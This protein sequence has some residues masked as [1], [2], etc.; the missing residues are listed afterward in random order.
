MTHTMK[1]LPEYCQALLDGT[2]TYELRQEDQTRHFA[3]N[4]QLVLCEWDVTR[5]SLEQRQDYAMARMDPEA[6]EQDEF[7]RLEALGYTGRRVTVEV[8]GDPLRDAR[9]LQPGVVA[10]SIRPITK[11]DAPAGIQGPSAKEA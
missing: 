9:W 5:L 4:D 2:K 8:I 3:R 7:L 10:L 11:T 6:W 1:I